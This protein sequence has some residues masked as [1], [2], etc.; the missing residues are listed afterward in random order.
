MEFTLSGL[1]FVGL[2]ARAGYVL[3]GVREP[4]RVTIL[5]GLYYTT[6][7]VPETNFGFVNLVGP[8]LFPVFRRAVKGGDSYSGYFKFSPLGKNFAV[9]FSSREIAIGGAYNWNRGANGVVSATLD[10][11]ELDAVIDGA[12]IH[13]TSF[14]VG[15]GYGL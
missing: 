4:W 9:N 13:S 10:I 8:Q 1:R 14:T 15:V 12:T 5:G 11:A 2:N 3:P 7:F 6:M